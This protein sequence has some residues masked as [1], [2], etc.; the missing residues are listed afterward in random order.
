MSSLEIAVESLSG[1]DDGALVKV[2]GQLDQPTLDKFLSE[3]GQVRQRGARRVLLDMQGVS[4]ANSTALGALVTQAD[5]FREAGGAFALL[6][7]QPKVNLII[8]MLGLNGCGCSSVEFGGKA[9]PG[10]SRRRVPHKERVLWVWVGVG[11]RSAGPLQVPSLR[12][13]LSGG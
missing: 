5:T 6:A 1:V 4:Y 10:A 7:P 2:T 12:L 13:S 11:V 9:G 3:L 8:E